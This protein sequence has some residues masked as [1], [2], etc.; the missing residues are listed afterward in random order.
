MVASI[1]V[2]VYLV[3]VSQLALGDRLILEVFQAK[4]LVVGCTGSTRVLVWLMA[5]V[6]GSV[7]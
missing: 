7:S 4:I 1:L 3:V 2:R 6:L 5:N